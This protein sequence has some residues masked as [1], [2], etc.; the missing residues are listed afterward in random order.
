[1]GIAQVCR[2][3]GLGPSPGAGLATGRSPHAGQLRP[4]G[5]AGRGEREGAETGSRPSAAP[6]G[7]GRCLAAGGSRLAGRGGAERGPALAQ[8]GRRAALL[9]ALRTP[10]SAPG[11]PLPVA[12]NV[13]QL[14][15]ETLEI[16]PLSKPQIFPC[17]FISAS[18]LNMGGL[19]GLSLVCPGSGM[20]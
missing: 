9:A 15:R 5:R 14:A 18:L 17:F 1:M 6:G 13:P 2:P 11:Y 16:A 7:L 19:S 4:A 10:G 8:A 20:V 3:A 12:G